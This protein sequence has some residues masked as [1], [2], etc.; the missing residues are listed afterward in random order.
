MDGQGQ[1]PR[2]LLGV[3][4]G[5]A[6]YKAA[7][8]ASRLCQEGCDIRV[9]MTEAAKRFVGPLTFAALT[10]N[11][12]PGD[13]FDAG[14]E[15]S[16]SHIDLA[17]WAQVVVVAPATAN[18]IAKAAAGLADD[19]LST[20][21]LATAAQLLIAPAMNPHM[22]AHP[23][24]GENLGRLAGRGA[25]IVGPADGRTACGEEG[26]GRMVEP[27]LIAEHVLDLL[28]ARDLEGVPILV[29]AG[30]TREHLDPVRYL[31]N[32][33]S[34]RM[35]IEVARV[36]R[37]RGARVTLVLGPTHLEPP[38]GVE[39]LRVTSAQEMA[40]AV[41][42]RA[43]AQRVIIKAAAVSDFRPQDRQPHKVKKSGS[44]EVCNLVSTP[45]I[46]AGL[47]RDKGDRVLVGFAAETQEVLAHASDKLKAKNLDLMVANDVS[48]ADSGF[49]VETN[50]VH[51]LTPDGEVETLP[52]MSKQEVAG[53]LLDRVARLLGVGA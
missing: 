45:D 30:P 29:T 14:Q 49:A 13:W 18:F 37:R 12:V 53:R 9:V 27:G 34:G 35:G 4:G 36:A 39:T 33:S 26:P 44:G 47:G 16:I 11:P 2:V 10:G 7:E 46:L 23:T 48:A 20:L 5:I 40:E 42:G 3:T 52:L 41:E 21:I 38:F 51:L 22:F 19:L 28:A 17:R 1:K 15:A 43:G 6:A 25:R 8:L 50:R 32:P 31:S 24:V